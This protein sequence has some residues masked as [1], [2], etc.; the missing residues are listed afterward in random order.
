MDPLLIVL[1]IVHI[2]SAIFG[3]GGVLYATHFVEPA[4]RDCGADGAQRA[5]GARGGP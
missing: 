2:V 4:L 3:A 5:A 1:R